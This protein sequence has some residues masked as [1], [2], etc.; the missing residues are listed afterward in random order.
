MQL[1]QDRAFGWNPP[2]WNER[3]LHDELWSLVRI[4]LRN[5]LKNQ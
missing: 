3:K 4:A 5:W 2:W 1:D